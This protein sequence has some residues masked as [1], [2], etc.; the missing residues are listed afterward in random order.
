LST[1]ISSAQSIWISFWHLSGPEKCWVLTH[2]FIANKARKITRE[3]ISTNE[4]IKID[5]TLDGD[6]NGGQV[7]AFRH[8]YW[9]ASLSQKICIRKALSLGKAHEKGNY[10]N[11]KKGKMDEEGQLPDS[12]SS[13]M[14]SY[15]N[16]AGASIGNQNKNLEKDS[17]RL[18]IKS[19]VLTGKL[20]I[21]FKNRAGKFLDCKGN[22]LDLPSFIHTWNT[23]KCLVNSDQ[24]EQIK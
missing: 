14:D 17:L 24:I 18:I 23:P 16:K 21:I 20:K 7:D 15:N 19:A 9:M 22:I 10:R 3:A 5:T 12:V 11:F 13:E 8:A 6:T 4:E 2:P 1:N